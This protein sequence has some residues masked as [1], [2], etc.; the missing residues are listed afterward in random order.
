[1]AEIFHIDLQQIISK[2]APNAAK[3][4]PRFVVKAL[5]NLICQDGLNVFLKENGAATG[6]DFMDNALKF[7][8]ITLRTEGE[9][10]LPEPSHKCIFASNHPLGGMDGICL[11]SLLGHRYDK[12]IRYLVNDILYFIE[13]LKDIFVPINKHGS[14]GRSAARTVNEA[15]AS[16]NQIITF[17]AGLCSRKTKGVICDP[18]WKKML[19][20]KAVEYQRDVVPVFFEAKN[21]AMFYRIANIR[22][23]TG[24]KFNIEM[25]FLPRELFKARG[26]S[27]TVYFGK[28]IPWQTFDSSKSPQEWT[29]W[30]KNIVY[31]TVR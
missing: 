14:Q 23:K 7:F 29:N 21:S 8:N 10:N 13:P 5:A 31:D 18:E 19:V 24:I 26:S 2:K 17:P 4:S 16:D 15:F 30:I 20:T 12:N 25:L 6:V 3:K 28:P 11:S 9:E 1:M 27:F 22:K